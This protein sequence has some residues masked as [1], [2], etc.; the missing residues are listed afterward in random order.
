[1]ALVKLLHH[2]IVAQPGTQVSSYGYMW[3][4][5]QEGKTRIAVREMDDATAKHWEDVGRV[6]IMAKS[7]I[8]PHG[9]EVIDTLTNTPS[10]YFGCESPQVFKDKIR[11]MN[12]SV[13][14]KL[15]K[16]FMNLDLDKSMGRDAL[17]DTVVAKAKE[18]AEKK[19]A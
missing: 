18:L 3:D 5:R 16:R 2:V 11:T 14:T 4:V 10:D 12:N 6:E 17:I 13:L 19:E 15:A 7:T 9:I 1:M 8:Q